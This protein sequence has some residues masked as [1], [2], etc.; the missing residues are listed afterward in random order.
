MGLAIDGQ[1]NMRWDTL[2]SVDDYIG[3]IVRMLE[4]AKEMENTYFL[5]TSDHG[6][7]LGQ[8]RLPGDKRHLYEHDIRIPFVLRGPGVTANHTVDSIVLS[9]DVAPTFTD[10][11]SGS[12]PDDMDGVSMLPLL[13][14]KKAPDTWRTD[15]MVDYHGQGRQP[16]GLVQ[17]PAPPADN[18]HLIDGYNNTYTCVRTLHVDGKGAD[19]M[20]CEFVDVNSQ[21]I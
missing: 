7:Q 16:C 21:A 8:H 12:V 15:F 17:C 14:S 10:I 2:L 4:D 13:G 11:A 19:S 18:F 3:E 1:H 5:F 6:F 20:Y 9:I